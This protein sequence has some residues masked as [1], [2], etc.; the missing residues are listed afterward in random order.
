M[1][2]I[3]VLTLTSKITN[4]LRLISRISADDNIITPINELYNYIISS[5]SLYAVAPSNINIQDNEIPE[6]FVNF[7]TG[8]LIQNSP[9]NY[10]GV[11]FEINEQG[12]LTYD[13]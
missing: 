1:A 10:T 3:E 4:E 2:S 9:N 6:L 8:G 13:N 7:E 11:D 5:N 12:E